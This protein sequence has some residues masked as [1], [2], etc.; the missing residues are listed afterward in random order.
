MGKLLYWLMSMTVFIVLTAYSGNLV[1]F[2]SIP[3]KTKPIND[4]EQLLAHETT[5]PSTIKNAFNHY[6]IKVRF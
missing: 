2:L 6:Y 4:L 1:A 5:I 3:M